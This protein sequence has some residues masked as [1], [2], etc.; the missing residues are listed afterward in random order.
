MSSA[1]RD[2][3]ISVHVA[4]NRKA[5]F[6]ALASDRGLSEAA[7]LSLMIDTVLDGNPTPKQDRSPARA[8]LDRICLRLRAGDGERVATRAQA[9]G[10]RPA[11]Y[12]STLVRAHLRAEPPLPSADLDAVKQVV[13]RLSAIDRHLAR[14]GAP[15]APLD[16][17]DTTSL[18]NAVASRVDEARR[19][20]ADV[21]RANLISWESGDV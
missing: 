21:V 17:V 6:A 2:P 18:L 19:A 5:A 9:R 15:G 7:L 10:M 13:N 20:V 8:R 14:L 16:W 1:A 12:L 4:R 11:T 3:L